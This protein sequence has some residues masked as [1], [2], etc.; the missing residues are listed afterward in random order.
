MKTV[1]PM[2]R[3]TCC[4]LA[5]YKDK[6]DSQYHSNPESENVDAAATGLTEDGAE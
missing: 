4:Q 2:R 1:P 3:I 5:K 6:F